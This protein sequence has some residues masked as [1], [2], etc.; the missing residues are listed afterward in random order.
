MLN[1]LETPKTATFVSSVNRSDWSE[2]YHSDPLA[3]PSQSSTWARS[4][5]DVG[6]YRDVSR[7]YEFDD[8]KRALLPLFAPKFA[9]SLLS[10]W[11]SPPAAWGFG[12][13]ISDAPLSVLQIRAVLADCAV[14][15]AAAMQVRPNPLIAATW[16]E[17]AAMAGWTPVNRC[18]HVLD[19]TGGFKYVW[20]RR[21]SSNTRS[22]V[23]RAGKA[24]IDIDRGCDEHQVMAFDTLFRRSIRR[25]AKKQNEFG[26]LAALRG[27]I[28]DPA[29]KFASISDT[30]GSVL[31]FW[32]ARLEGRPVAGIVVLADGNA[33]YTRGA[34]DERFIGNTYASHLLQSNAIEAAA[35]AGCRH[36]HLGETGGSDSLAQ[37]K[38]SFGA[39]AMPYAEFRFE[40]LPIL[41]AD[42]KLRGIV[43]TMIGFRDV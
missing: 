24:G 1:R 13:L 29:S 34:I 32:I 31:N 37:F 5:A 19:L 25:W 30:S 7:F 21:F 4:I 41:T 6:R 35:D 20:E 10:V 23:R 8:G 43:K 3:M 39:V 2:I 42:Q 9:P 27:R 33:H 18:A 12:G 26:W 38:S 40:R 14:L 11:Q 16:A 36:Y 15:P 28:R 17:A 22:K